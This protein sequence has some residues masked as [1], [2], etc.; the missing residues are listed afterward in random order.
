MFAIRIVLVQ[1]VALTLEQIDSILIVLEVYS[2]L[3]NIGLVAHGDHSPGQFPH[4][5]FLLPCDI[6]PWFSKVQQVMVWNWENFLM[7]T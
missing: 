4:C 5:C 7:N 6:G 3:F 1:P 2:L